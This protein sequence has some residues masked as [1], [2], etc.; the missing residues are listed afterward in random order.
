MPD[1]DQADD[2]YNDSD[3]VV[4]NTNGDEDDHDP[5]EIMV[6]PYYDL[7]LIKAYN[8]TTPFVRD[9]DMVTFDLTVVNQGNVT[10]EGVEITDYVP[11]GLVLADSAWTD[12]GDGTAS[13]VIATVIPA[14]DTHELSITFEVDASLGGDIFTNWAEISADNAADFG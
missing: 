9:G 11:A 13:H 7:A 3:D 6:D 12:N 1:A 14:G 8:G 5:A 4:D 10:G 2:V